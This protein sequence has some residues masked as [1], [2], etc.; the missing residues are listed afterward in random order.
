MSTELYVKRYK[1]FN[2]VIEALNNKSIAA[3]ESP[4]GTGKTLC[5]LCSTLGWVNAKRK[6]L[7]ESSSD[8]KVTPPVIYYSTRTHSQ[9]SNVIYR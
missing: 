4:T 7:I 9:I 5:L 2:T 3:L 1:Y 8:K 6:E